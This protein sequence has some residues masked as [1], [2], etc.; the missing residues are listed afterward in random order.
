[1]TGVPALLQDCFFVLKAL[2]LGDPFV[3]SAKEIGL[4]KAKERKKTSLLSITHQSVMSFASNTTTF[5]IFFL[6]K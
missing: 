5:T 4:V 6:L 3:K 2:A 1:M